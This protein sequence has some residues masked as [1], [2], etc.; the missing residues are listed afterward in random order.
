MSV[1]IQVMHSK[2]I[3]LALNSMFSTWL[4]VALLV[5]IY[6]TIIIIIITIIYPQIHVKP[7]SY[8]KI[9]HERDR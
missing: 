7:Q 8:T 9:L 6:S 5:G 3:L 2:G 1:A 4:F